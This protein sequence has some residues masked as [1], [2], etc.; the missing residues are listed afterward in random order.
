MNANNIRK[1]MGKEN[2]GTISPSLPILGSI[3]RRRSVTHTD[4]SIKEMIMRAPFI[5]TVEKIGGSEEGDGDR[6]SFASALA[7][8]IRETIVP[9]VRKEAL[10]ESEKEAQQAVRVVQTEMESVQAVNKEILGRGSP[11]ECEKVFDGR[12]KKLEMELEETMV[13]KEEVEAMQVAVER[14]LQSRCRRQTRVHRRCNIEKGETRDEEGARKYHQEQ[15]REAQSVS[16]WH[17]R[18]RE[19]ER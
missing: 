13:A 19:C 8:W 1:V 15:S 2:A 7:L 9:A 14:V 6:N 5:E 3:D 18:K 12:L 4:D 11:E 17:H 16:C 10:N